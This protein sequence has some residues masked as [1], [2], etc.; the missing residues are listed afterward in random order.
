[1]TFV[2]VNP[3]PK[4]FNNWVN[5]VLNVPAVNRLLEDDFFGGRLHGFPPVNIAESA[6]GYELEVAA[7]G[8][9]KADFKIQLEKNVLTISYDKKS[10]TDQ[11]DV[12]QVRKEFSQRSFKRSFTVD[13]NVD[14]TNISAKYENGLLKLALPKKA[15][16]KEAA[17]DIT[18]A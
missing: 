8:L 15:E 18:I 4:H 3:S 10:E 9:D 14:A 6:E 11:K 7:P 2:K 17:K 12:K 13:E 16:V 5:D 1:M